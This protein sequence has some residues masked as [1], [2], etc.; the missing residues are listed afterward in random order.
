M[1]GALERRAANAAARQ[2]APAARQGT[3]LPG[4]AVLTA[5]VAPAAAA[6]TG[7]QGQARDLHQRYLPAASKTAADADAH[8]ACGPHG[9]GQSRRPSWRRPA[10]R[11]A[12]HRVRAL[13]KVA[14]VPSGREKEADDSTG[15]ITAPKQAGESPAAALI[16]AGHLAGKERHQ[17]RRLVCAR[18]RLAETAGG[19]T[20]EIRWL[21]ARRAG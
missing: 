12:G 4:S 3:L 17:H 9:T 2:Q 10:S 11:P 16:D 15:E 20:A 19:G 8:L 21:P 1:R 13:E 5:G 14:G 6:V 7:I 18:S